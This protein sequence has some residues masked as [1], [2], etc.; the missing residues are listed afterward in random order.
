MRTVRTRALRIGHCINDAT[1]EGDLRPK[2][3]F[4]G[5]VSNYDDTCWDV[6]EG[7]KSV[8]LTVNT[9]HGYQGASLSCADLV[10]RTASDVWTGITWFRLDSGNTEKGPRVCNGPAKV[11]VGMLSVGYSWTDE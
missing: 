7:A 3:N 1:H 4:G 5:W 9:D 11:P 6:P 2:S 8:A 10:K